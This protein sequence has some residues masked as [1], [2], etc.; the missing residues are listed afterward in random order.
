MRS[1]HVALWF[2]AGCGGVGSGAAKPAAGCGP[3]AVEAAAASATDTHVT[4]APTSGPSRASASLVSLAGDVREDG[5]V[6]LV[7]QVR[8][9]APARFAAEVAVERA[10]GAT[11]APFAADAMSLRFACDA[12]PAA[13]LELV[14][15][16]EL[17]PPAW[18]ATTG[19]AQCN[20]HGPDRAPPGR[21]RFVARTCDGAR[22]EGE[23]F[24]LH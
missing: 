10:A 14:P 12:P 16:A 15:G 4:H 18:L 20:E 9:T 19:R 22:I 17:R 2:L 3:P 13:C 7:L 11:F 1:R 5:A 23:A 6:D 24:E 21:Y 8:D